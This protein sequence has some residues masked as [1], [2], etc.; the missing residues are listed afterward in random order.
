MRGFEGQGGKKQRRSKKPRTAR[1]V[2]F[3]DEIERGSQEFISTLQPPPPAPQDASRLTNHSQQ[4]DFNLN[5][6]TNHEHNYEGETVP[7]NRQVQQ[8]QDYLESEDHMQ[9]KLLEEKHW[10]EVYE[11]MFSRFYECSA[12]TSDW[13]DPAKTARSRF[14]DCQRDQVRLVQMGYI[15]GAPKFPRTAFSIRLL[16]LHHI[17]WKR[18]GV[19]MSPFSKSIDEFLDAYN[20]LILVPNSSDGT[21]QSYHTREWRRTMSSAVDA[22]REML[23]REKLIHERMMAMGPL[24][25]LAEKS[26][27][28]SP[29]LKRQSPSLFVEPQEVSDMERKLKQATQASTDNVDDGTDRCTQQHT[30]ADDVR[31]G[32]TW[33]ECDDTGLFGMA[34]RHDQILQ[35]INIVQSGEKAHFPM[36]M[37]NKLI[38]DTK[39]GEAYSK[40]LGFLYDIGCNI[41]KGIIR[42]NQFPEHLEFNLLRF[43]TSVFH[44]YVHQWSC[45]LRYNPRLNDGWGMS[46]GEGMERIWAFLSP[47]VRQLRYATKNHRLVALDIRA[48]HHNDIGRTGK[49]IEQEK[50]KSTEILRQ[51]E[52]EFGHNI[53]N[54]KGQWDRQRAIQLSVMETATEKEML[55][56]IEELVELEDKL[57]EANRELHELR[58]TRRRRRTTVQSSRL[59]QIPETLTV[60]EAEIGSLVAE[61]GSEN[62]RNLP[63]ASNAQSKA[64]IKLKVSKSKLYEAKVGV[65]EMQQ[66]WDTGGSGTRVQARY[67]KQ[68][69]EKVRLLKNKWLA[70]DHRA[71]NYNS[72]FT[73]Q[74][75]LETPT[76][77]EVKSFGME[78]AFWNMG[79][80]SHP[81]EPW[82]IDSN[83]QKGISAY[84]TLIHCQDELN[85]ISREARQAVKWALQ[86]DKKMEDIYT[87][88]NSETQTR[89]VDISSNHHFS[90]SVLQSIFQNSAKRHC[91][92]W[93]SWNQKCRELLSWSDKY[94]IN[95]PDENS[96][97]L[98]HW[99]SLIVKSQDMWEK[100]VKGQSVIMEFGDQADHEEEEILDQEVLEHQGG[101]PENFGTIN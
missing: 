5:N 85:R 21:D 47:L 42:R 94:V 6:D 77:E 49:H 92:L 100:L 90:K 71:Q 16:R 7:I 8:L 20:P 69:N 23:R 60:I 57:Q 44:A 36:T 91:R 26:S 87:A 58:Q 34:C 35:L 12:K 61:L 101:E 24:N 28:E 98:E 38:E 67:K 96:T 11:G 84:L 48:S 52:F 83:I 43:G 27:V 99:D 22:Y 59:E 45:Q 74:T 63:G 41:E 95:Q 97:L 14:C 10:E 80:V 3:Q 50:I 93:M 13:G 68:M 39:E 9:K 55:D 54:L 66:K 4:Q 56:Q 32:K 31:T 79:P 46:D 40:K 33:K 73:P 72:E 25:R 89:M 75:A 2:A 51:I 82:A 81:N 30:A 29:Q 86:R 37:I 88:L 18:S 19:A 76:L 15:G 65:A 1:G 17:M 78:D 70:Y 64:L 62:F 53:D